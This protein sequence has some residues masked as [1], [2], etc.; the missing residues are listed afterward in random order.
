MCVVFVI[1]MN[2]AGRTIRAC[3]YKPGADQTQSGNGLA[4]RANARSADRYVPD[5][6]W[7]AGIMLLLIPANRAW[8][9]PDVLDV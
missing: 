5:S 2:L 7:V 3:S 8:P 4:L 1:V 9:P 6:L